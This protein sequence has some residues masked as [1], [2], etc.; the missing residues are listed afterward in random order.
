MQA[1]LDTR[2]KR[3]YATSPGF[4]LLCPIHPLPRRYLLVSIS[5]PQLP[6]PSLSPSLP[7]SFPL[8]TSS[9]SSLFSTFDG[10][11]T[12]AAGPSE[13]RAARPA[14]LPPPPPRSQ[15]AP[16][17][18]A[19]RGRIRCSR[20]R[21]RPGWLIRR[22]RWPVQPDGEERHRGMCCPQEARRRKASLCQGRQP[23]AG[24]GANG[25]HSAA[26]VD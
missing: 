3:E 21:R 5:P 19:R 2:L 20:R 23:T 11:R 9:H 1:S 14:T 10:R 24:A 13:G 6:S 26:R 17:E 12:S 15:G 22:P 8:S 25:S 7:L 18:E 16:R 4:V